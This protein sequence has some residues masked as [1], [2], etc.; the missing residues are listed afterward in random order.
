[1]LSG[2]LSEEILA[3]IR[4]G[5]FIE[6]EELL[7]ELETGLLAMRDDAHDDEMVNAAFRAVHSIKGGAATFGYAKLSDFSHAFESALEA[8]RAKT[9]DLDADLIALLLRASDVLADI[10]H[11]ARDGDEDAPA[12]DDRDALV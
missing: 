5:F 8:V 1:M 11:A 4:A 12:A 6:C 10:V 3:P 9:I 7:A 2:G